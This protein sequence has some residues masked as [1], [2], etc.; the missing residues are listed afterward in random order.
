VTGT[1]APAMRSS[2][3]AARL[4]EALLAAGSPAVDEVSNTAHEVSNTAHEAA[5]SS[6]EEDQLRSS[7]QERVRRVSLP[8]VHGT[9][10]RDDGGAHGV[11]GRLGAGG[12]ARRL[13]V[14]LDVHHLA[15]ARA[16]ARKGRC[17]G[18][19]ADDARRRWQHAI[20]DWTA[21][22]A[23]RSEAAANVSGGVFFFVALWFMQV[24]LAE[25]AREDTDSAIGVKEFLVV[26]AAAGVV[27][28]LVGPQPLIVLRPTGPVVLILVQLY[29]ISKFAWPV[30]NEAGDMDETE[31]QQSQIDHFLQFTAAV[32]LFVG[33]YMA[34]IAALELSRW[35]SH[36]TRFTLEI[37]EMFVSVRGGTFVVCFVCRSERS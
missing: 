31:I 25:V 35:C 7:W 13:S 19:V 4:R 1:G 29:E 37:F 27:Q 34:L 17:C 10:Q 12:G 9:G 32:G 36:I 30:T 21:P 14:N 20:T 15:N 11:R 26:N 23:S 24:A 5:Q 22:F 16:L 3:D 18:G 33:G 2:A 6:D 28:S 8:D